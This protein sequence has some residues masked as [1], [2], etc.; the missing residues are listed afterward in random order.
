MS[1]VTLKNKRFN[2]GD[3][4]CLNDDDNLGYVVRIIYVNVLS[5]DF[6][7]KKQKIA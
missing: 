4:V 1:I 5:N 3:L 6:K 2:M 7:N